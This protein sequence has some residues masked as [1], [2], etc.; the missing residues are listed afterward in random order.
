MNDFWKTFLVQIIK[1]SA[2]SLFGGIAIDAFLMI[3]FT[4]EMNSIFTSGL[5]QNK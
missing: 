4:Q 2:V 1:I 3:I 5:L